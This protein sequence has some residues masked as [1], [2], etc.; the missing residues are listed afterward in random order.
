MSFKVRKFKD[1]A[2][3]EVSVL[4]DRDNQPYFWP[5]VYATTYYR[6]GSPNTAIG[7]L[8]TLGMFEIWIS[9]VGIDGSKQIARGEF[10][11]IHQVESLATFLRLTRPAQ[12]QEILIS[13][14]VSA[15]NVTRLESARKPKQPFKYKKPSS[16]KSRFCPKAEAIRRFR[17]VAK[18]LEYLRDRGLSRCSSSQEKEDLTKKADRIIARLRTLKPRGDSFSFMK[19]ESLVGIDKEETARIDKILNPASDSDLN[20]FKT[21]FLRARNYLMWRLFVD[22]GMR[23][24]ELIWLEVDDLNYG[25]RRVSVRISKTRPRT[26]G[27]IEKTAE[28]FHHFIMEHWRKLPLKSTAHGRLFIRE[29]GKPLELRSI[30]SI[31]SRL[32]EAVP[33]VPDYLEP[34][35]MRRSWNDHFS[36]TIDSLAPES[37]PTPEE[38]NALR[39][40]LM[41]WS[42][43]SQMA[44]LYTKR[45]IA[46]K[47]DAIAEKMANDILKPGRSRKPR[48]NADE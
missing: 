32:V 29:D 11:D 36:E 44:A 16:E 9:S 28:A 43:N 34:H 40:R 45:H 1:H 37:R 5:N 19:N 25:T 42:D 15:N 35:T 7:V 26:L 30:N 48:E 6:S 18:F 46:K 38:E 2:D 12:D 8:T 22:T 23:R 13:K 27:F 41:G 3:D 4:V 21:P 47:A 20:P 17:W 14:G 33:G 39:N 31:F 24:G 10:I